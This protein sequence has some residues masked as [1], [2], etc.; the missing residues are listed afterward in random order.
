MPKFKVVIAHIEEEM[1]VGKSIGTNL[2]FVFSSPNFTVTHNHANLTSEKYLLAGEL[3]LTQDADIEIS[4]L[5]TEKDKYPD[6]GSNSVVIPLGV[7]DKVKSGV[8]SVNVKENYGPVVPGAPPRPDPPP[9]AV[10]R[11]FLN[12]TVEPTDQEQCQDRANKFV[13]DMN[14]AIDAVLPTVGPSCKLD[15]AALA[16]LL[17]NTANHES[18]CFERVE[19]YSHGKGEGLIQMEPKTYE[20]L[21]G[22]Y[23]KRPVNAKLAAALRQLAGPGTGTPDRGLLKTNPCYAAGMAIT[24]YIDHHA[25]TDFPLPA[26]GDVN[27]QSDYWLEHYRTKRKNEDQKKWDRLKKDFVDHHDRTFSKATP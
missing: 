1:I 25:G 24:R 6:K 16:S 22:D 10:F 8:L 14:T 23:L 17:L 20:Y 2:S 13:P 12:L 4:C 3:P 7:A 26:A 19:Q 15:R 5:V 21:W 9:E 27:A 18:N 11:I